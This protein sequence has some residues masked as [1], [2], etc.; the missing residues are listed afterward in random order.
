[1]KKGDKDTIVL[2]KDGQEC[3]PIQKQPYRTNADGMLLIPDTVPKGRYWM[4]ESS[5]PYK[6][7]TG[8]TQYK[9][10]LSLYMV[11]VS[12]YK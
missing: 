6:G 12:N 8:K 4:V 1:M 5:T 3:T 2:K 11:E 7:V 9:D 10:N